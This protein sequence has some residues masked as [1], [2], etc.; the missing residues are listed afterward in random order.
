MEFRYS[1]AVD[2]GIIASSCLTILPVR[3]SKYQEMANDS[4]LELLAE[5]NRAGGK[6]FVLDSCID[7]GGHSLS[8]SIPETMPDRIDVVARLYDFG[9][10]QDDLN[11]VA[12][13]ATEASIL[14]EMFENTPELHAANSVQL[15]G[16]KEWQNGK[17]QL[18]AKLL[19]DAIAIDRDAGFMIRDSWSQW[20]NTTSGSR[21]ANDFQSF[22]EWTGFRYEN[23]AIP[24]THLIAALGTGVSISKEE[25]EAVAHVVR[26]VL[27]AVTLAN[28][29]Y[30]FDKEVIQ[31]EREGGTT[32]IMNSIW[33]LMRQHGID[34][35][36]A[37]RLLA[38]KV[39]QLEREYLALREA[40]EKANPNMPQNVK[41][42]IDVAAYLDSGAQYWMSFCS[43][44][45][46]PEYRRKRRLSSASGY[47]TPPSSAGSADK[48]P[49]IP[50]CSEA[51]Q[52]MRVPIAGESMF[53]N[54]SSAPTFANNVETSFFTTATVQGIS[55]EIV[56]APYKYISSLPSKGVR[57]AAITALDTWLN[58]PEAPLSAIR[59]VTDYI[60]NTT[61]LIDDIQD[62]S[63]LRR[64]SPAA[65]TIFGEA[66]VI[67][68]ATY[69][70]TL[71]SEEVCRLQNP[72]SRNIY[73]AGVQ[74]LHLGQSM[75]LLWT[76]HMTCPTIPEY[77][78]MIDNKTGAL[79]SL[80]GELMRAE[81][82]NPELPIDRTM[83]L[84]GRYFQIR[85]DYQ[86]LES[87]D[88]TAAKG[89]CEDLDE[90]K[91][92]LALIHVM[93][94]AGTFER[95]LLREILQER[96][97][98]GEMPVESKKKVVDMMRRMGSLD[99]VRGVI[100]EL[101]EA[102]EGEIR[103]VEEVVG[104]ENYVMRLLLER[105]RII[106]PK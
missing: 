5:Y 51:E 54:S 2:P 105:L 68:C 72:K 64:G 47:P 35:E 14:N 8:L 18:A 40:Y 25:I 75:D 21:P 73:E 31:Y 61:L 24:C 27:M 81:S 67:N 60:H 83:A 62:N 89:F 15:N 49:V 3:I 101:E 70:M 100:G 78:K 55:D 74:R 33:I 37:R 13:K 95:I 32:G 71:A 63:P 69:M 53:L 104:G 7:P 44:Y 58:I 102:I 59:V 91:F 86:N 85:D 34:E 90:G 17:R 1:T 97:M 38:Q 20:H 12:D 56:L 41:A 103:A 23:A 46:R 79:L 98:K 87:A 36:K 76:R 82:S 45:N 10:I 93:N 80:V 84:L 92:S 48:T 22:D 19:L 77:I 11:D 88:Y 30:S 66:Q 50:S 28:D 99:Y 4:S 6:A 29:Y 42:W 39:I 96:R 57:K 16:G 9:F 65:H 52:H 94:S 26:P 106:V 43:R